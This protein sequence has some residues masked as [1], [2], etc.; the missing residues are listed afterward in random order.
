MKVYNIKGV[1]GSK[2]RIY[3]EN[4][5]DPKTGVMTRCD[6]RFEQ[7]D[8]FFPSMHE[9]NIL[10]IL[11]IFFIILFFLSIYILKTNRDYVAIRNEYYLQN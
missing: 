8:S 6:T 11:I 7:N 3:E 5:F 9:R 4:D 10:L 2:W 1:D